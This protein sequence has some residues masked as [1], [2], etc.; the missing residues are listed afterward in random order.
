[1]WFINQANVPALGEET[2]DSL[3]QIMEWSSMTIGVDVDDALAGFC[4]VLE[5]GRPYPSQN[6]LWFQE[7]YTNFIYLDRVGFGRAH[8]SRGYGAALYAE[9]ERRAS[10]IETTPSSFTLE[11]NL[12]PPND[13]S[14]RF[15]LRQGFVEVGRQRTPSGKLVSLMAKSLVEKRA[16]GR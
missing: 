9:V 14:M 13:G 10:L 1:M 5:P 4:L 3:G 7:R 11:V 8:R 2:P 15:H 6:Y 16:T 12:D